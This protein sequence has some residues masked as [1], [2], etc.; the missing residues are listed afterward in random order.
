MGQTPFDFYDV[1]LYFNLSRKN[2]GPPPR[3]TIL[4]QLQQNIQ[5]GNK[6]QDIFCHGNGLLNKRHNG[7]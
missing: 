7:L 6:R 4:G 3:Y 1:M 2:H 5:G